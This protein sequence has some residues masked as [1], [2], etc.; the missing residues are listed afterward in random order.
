LEGYLIRNFGLED[1]TAS[2][3]MKVRGILKGFMR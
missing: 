1:K 3:T 2:K